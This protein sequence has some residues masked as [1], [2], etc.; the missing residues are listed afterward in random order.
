LRPSD[1]P[2]EGCT[3]LVTGAGAVEVT[4]PRV[5]DKHTD[6]AAG[7]PH[8]FCSAI[9]PR[10]V[11]RDPE[12][13]RGA[14]AAPARP[15]RRGLRLPVAD[16]IHVNVLLEEDKLSLPVMIGVRA[17]GRRELIALAD[18]YRESAESWADLLRDCARRGMR[19]P[20][21]VVGTGR[22][23]SRMRCA[24]CSPRPGRAGAGSTRPPT[25]WPRWPSRPT[26]DEEGAGGDLGRRGQA[27]CPGC[28][29]GVR[30]GLQRKFPSPP[31]TSLTT[32]PSCW[33][34]STTR[35]STGMLAVRG[36]T[37]LAAGRWPPRLRRV[38]HARTAAY[39]GARPQQRQ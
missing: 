7:E 21:L 29:E 16:G 27:A 35:P 36:R 12:D 26:G 34:S 22:W 37:N 33:P 13:H 14:A 25:S 11:P 2:G 5:N 17:D 39:A 24:R 19:A 4:A 8:R 31:R 10:W 1:R 6:P 32:W 3:F 28:G 30:G 38:P 20:V 23:G 9:L 15:V 18:G